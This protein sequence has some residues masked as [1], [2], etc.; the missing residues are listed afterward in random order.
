MF[1]GRL[2]SRVSGE[3]PPEVSLRALNNYKRI[4]L[5]LNSILLFHY[6]LI[7]IPEK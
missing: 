6:Y 1:E 4:S 3:L 2:T 5:Q 7:T